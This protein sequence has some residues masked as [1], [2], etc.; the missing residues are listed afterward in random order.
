[1]PY[2]LASLVA[3]FL[4]PVWWLGTTA[5]Q[6][7]AA[8]LLLVLTM[9]ATVFPAYAL[10]RLVVSPWYA[11]AAAGG[12]TAVPALA[13]SPILVEEP[14]AYPLATLA[15]FLIAR[16]LV[17]PRLENASS[18]GDR[19][20]RGRGHSDQL[21]VLFAVL[22][23]GLVWIAW[24][25]ER[26]RHWRST[27]STWDWVGAAA[28]V[29][30]VAVTFSAVM[31]HLST[32]WRNTTLYYKDRIFDHGVSAIGALAIGIGIL[33]LVAGIAALARPKDEPTDPKTR[34]FVTT[35]AAALATFVLVRGHQGRVPVDGLRDARRRAER[36][37]PGAA[38][39]SPRRRSS[40]SAASAAGGRSRRQPSSRL[41]RR[42]DP[43]SSSTYPY[44]EAHGLSIASF[45]N[46]EWGWPHGRIETALIVVCVLA[47]AVV[48]ALRWLAP[49]LARVRV[50]AGVRGGARRD[51]ESHGGGLC[52]LGR[53]ATSR[54]RSRSNLPRPLD[55]VDQATRWR[56]DGRA[57]AADHRSD[58]RPADRVLQ[59]VDPEDVEPR[60]HRHQRRRPD[61]HARPRRGE[62]D[63]LPGAGNAVRPRPE[64]RRAARAG[65]RAGRAPTRCTGSTAARCACSRPPRGSRRTAG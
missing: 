11:L 41:R 1:M 9:T 34:A 42:R 36:H 49:R 4:A 3:Y 12:A 33:P 20:G 6:Y 27:W 64:R 46:R 45:A 5:A 28:L 51:L 62:R 22:A 26:G 48:L 43:A 15:L 8:K 61:P 55:W 58:G 25:S 14:L 19:V 13:Y 35:T 31:S 54:G 16:S 10:A 18:R 60:R 32:S 59:H 53:A 56:V 38:R 29:V 7:S 23:L 2:G 50:V 24:Q 52:R 44:Y 17:R 65:R 57:R 63:A 30:G 39:S 40:S 21:V 37:L 47:V